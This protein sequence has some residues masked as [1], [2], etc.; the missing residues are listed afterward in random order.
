MPDDTQI[1]LGRSIAALR[2]ELDTRTAERDEALARQSATSE[3]LS[4]IARSP[5]DVQPVFD[6]I[7]GSAARLCEA[8]FSAV[9][10][11]DEG[12]ALQAR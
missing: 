11:F 6:A 10:R 4:V 2:R 3:I 9:A 5:T 7:V 8:E 1:D 12:C